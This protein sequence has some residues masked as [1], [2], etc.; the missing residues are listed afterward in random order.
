MACRSR[1]PGALSSGAAWISATSSASSPPAPTSSPPSPRVPACCATTTPS[2]D[3][4]PPR[5]ASTAT[6]PTGG[7]SV[8]EQPKQ[9]SPQPNGPS[10]T[11]GLLLR[12]GQAPLDTVQAYQ[13]ASGYVAL[14]QALTLRPGQVIEEARAAQLRGR[15]G[16]GVLAAEK[17]LLVAQADA[18][19][20]YLVCNA[21]D[22]DARSLVAATLLEQTPHLIVEGMALAAY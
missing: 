8:P 21:Y 13:A 12:P 18:D 9:Q 7:R 17:L 3:P 15:G 16:A 14:R 19:A 11:Q 1:W 22:A 4:R 20:K 5:A 10:A 6:S 2:A